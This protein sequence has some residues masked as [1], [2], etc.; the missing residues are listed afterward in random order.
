MRVTK[1]EFKFFNLIFNLFYYFINME[2]VIK[3]QSENSIVQTF[4]NVNST[5][6]NKN[7]DFKIPEGGV[8]DL[9]ESYI[10]LELQ[11]NDPTAAIGGVAVP[12]AKMT[13]ALDTNN[14]GVF[15][16][17][18]RVFGAGLVRNVQFYSQRRGMLE[19]VRRIDT[20]SMIKQS[21]ELDEQDIQSDM[22][23]VGDL[24]Q[25][26]LGGVL[27]T[28]FVDEV[29]VTNGDGIDANGNGDN[30]SRNRPHETRIKLKDLFGL[31]KAKLFST[32]KY[33]ECKMN[34]EL[35]LDKIKLGF[36]QG[37]EGGNGGPGANI[38]LNACDDNNG[39]ANGAT[40]DSLVLTAEAQTDPELNCPFM[41]GQAINCA[42][43]GS[44]SGAATQTSIIRDITYA[45]ATRK[46]T[47]S[48][49][50]A[51]ITNGS[52]GAENYTGITITP[53]RAGD[54]SVTINNAELNLTEVLGAD[55]GKVPD[56]INY[57][58]Y[59]TEEMDGAG[60]A[61]ANKRTHL[62]PNCQTLYVAS[63]ET[64]KIAPART[65]SKYRLAIDNEDVSGNR[66]IDY[67]DQLH[68]ERITRAYVNKNVPLKNLEL[69]LL[70]HSATQA[71]MRTERLNVIVEPMPL[72]DEDKL[73]QLEMTAVAN[74]QDIILYKELVV[75][76]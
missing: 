50:R 20:L 51:V 46:F 55:A 40:I 67:F 30:V 48:F 17:N 65:M 69:V 61:T 75:S 24:P 36:I 47:V 9:S 64:G 63:C 59:S 19:S 7:L 26:R 52:G 73:A 72:T 62:E 53:L 5:P 35:N 28:A 12:A 14:F 27:T 49:T 23:G 21:L 58:T 31:G 70:R 8:Y 6:T 66:D 34:L 29:R 57:I 38:D 68:K 22:N 37:Q 10:A 18:H 76:K 41:V 42:F 74:N 39:V 33:G 45:G 2:R 13:L 54:P 11:L 71:N 43:T 3:I 60:L 16:E 56:E 25:E 15:A 32:D 1:L 44:V 4:D